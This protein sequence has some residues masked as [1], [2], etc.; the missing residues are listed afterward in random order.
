[1]LGLQN[2]IKKL[3]DLKTDAFE[4]QHHTYPASHLWVFINGKF[5][6]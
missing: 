5:V 6:R 4:R 3:G 2:D 1:M